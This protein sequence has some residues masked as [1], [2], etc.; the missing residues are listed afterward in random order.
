MRMAEVK[1]ASAQASTEKVGGFDRRKG[2]CISIFG[3]ILKAR[4]LVHEI[5]WSTHV[6]AHC[7]CVAGN[8]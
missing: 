1:A 2:T 8:L 3:L 5:R 6:F 4:C 7:M